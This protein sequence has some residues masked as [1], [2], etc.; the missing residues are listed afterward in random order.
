MFGCYRFRRTNPIIGFYRYY[1]DRKDV[2]RVLRHIRRGHDP[3]ENEGILFYIVNNNDFALRGDTAVLE[4]LVRAGCEV[5]NDCIRSIIENNR[6]QVL[7][8]L[9]DRGINLGFRPTDLIHR[10]C[11]QPC[12]YDQQTGEPHEVCKPVLEMVKVFVKHGADLTV[13]DKT[14]IPATPLDRARAA[15]HERRFK[16]RNEFGEMTYATAINPLLRYLEEHTRFQ[17]NIRKTFPTA[18]T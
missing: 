4:S 17:E 11:G 6:Y 12:Y 8:F 3:N 15:N 1:I 14:R 5:T 16:V 13:R 10:V 7:D 18:P 9:W 2:Q